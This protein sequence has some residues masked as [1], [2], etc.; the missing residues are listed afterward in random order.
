LNLLHFVATCDNISFYELLG[1]RDKILQFESSHNY[2][3]FT[4]SPKTKQFQQLDNFFKLEQQIEQLFPIS[5]TN[6]AIFSKLEQLF[7]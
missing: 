2:S 3:R 4:F 6:M 5:A 7:W 1:R